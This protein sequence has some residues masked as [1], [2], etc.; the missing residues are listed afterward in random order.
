M[1]VYIDD[2]NFATVCACDWCGAMTQTN[3]GD[4][5]VPAGWTT[6]QLWLTV[7]L[8]EEKQVPLVFCEVCGPAALEAANGM[9]AALLSQFGTPAA[10]VVETEA[11]DIGLPVD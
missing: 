6:G 9:L 3:R 10:Q 2:E 1:P 5:V 4:G 11:V 7:S 8:Q